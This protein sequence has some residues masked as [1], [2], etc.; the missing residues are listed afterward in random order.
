M[1]LGLLG[2]T[3]DPIHYGHMVAAEETLSQLGLDR[4][5]FIPAGQP[6]HKV[7]RVRSALE[8]RV[9][10]VELAIVSNPKFALSLVDAQRTGPAYSVD[11]VAAL[12]EQQ[13][14]GTEFFFIIG[15][16][17]LHD[18][19]SW[20]DPQRLV[21][22]C[23]LA[24]VSRPGYAFDIEHLR[25]Y[26]PGIEERVVFV[27]IPEMGISSTDLRR[28]VAASLPI[29]YQVPESVEGY[30]YALGLYQ[31]DSSRGDAPPM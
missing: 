31:N 15:A 1:K 4:V 21:Q 25:P 22:L 2:G 5:L 29:K 6:P 24:V 27:P 11:T 18:L 13:G 3:F 10:M 28:R 30:I 12:I 26:I 17:S 20:R 9:R 23:Q 7:G 16:D 14:P 8:V 19:L